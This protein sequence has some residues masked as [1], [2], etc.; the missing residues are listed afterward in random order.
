MIRHTEHLDQCLFFFF[1]LM[2]MLYGNGIRS[3]IFQLDGTGDWPYQ[4]NS[5]LASG[6]PRRHPGCAGE[7]TK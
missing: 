6:K 2:C 3:P 4:E 5:H 7:L 1:F